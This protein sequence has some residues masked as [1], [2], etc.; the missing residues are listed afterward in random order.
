VLL[1]NGEV[2]QGR[3]LGDGQ[4]YRIE[5]ADGGAAVLPHRDIWRVERSLRD[6]YEFRL[7]DAE[8]HGGAAHFDLARWCLKQ[9][10]YAEASVQVAIAQRADLDAEMLRDLRARIEVAVSNRQRQAAR[11]TIPVRQISAPDPLADRESAVPQPVHASELS[12]PALEEFSKSIQPLLI[13]RCGNATCHGRASQT[14]FRLAEPPRRALYTPRL[15]QRNAA[16]S[17]Q[18]VNFAASS[19][20]GLLE[21]SARPHAGMKSAALN[22]EQLESLRR[23]LATVTGKSPADEAAKRSASTA[24]APR[25]LPCPPDPKATLEVDSSHLEATDM[26]HGADQ[27]QAA[28][29]SGDPFD[30]Q[31]FNRRHHPGEDEWD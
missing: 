30:P 21:W 10:L 20:S 24:L 26:D 8:R 23:W 1:H 16:A 6:L 31:A 12:P 28:G 5:L 22:Q 2:L 4:R 14:D 9:Q 18:Y 11:P 7:Q 19:A 3:I 27:A 25:G 15:T 13:N 29:E 17:L